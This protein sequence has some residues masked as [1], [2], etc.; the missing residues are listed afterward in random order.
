MVKGRV[1]AV[2]RSG[3]ST[4]DAF[5]GQQQGAINTRRQARFQQRLFE[6]FKVCQSRELIKR[7]D[8]K[9]GVFSRCNW[10]NGS[11]QSEMSPNLN[12]ACAKIHLMGYFAII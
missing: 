1:Y 2:S 11:G 7:R 10:G 5:L 3:Y 8:N 12:E 9:R 6:V 4:I